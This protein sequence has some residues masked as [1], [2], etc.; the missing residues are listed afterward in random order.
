MP[1]K[2]TVER[3]DSF[4]NPTIEDILAFVNGGKYGKFFRSR[5]YV[6]KDGSKEYLTVKGS[7][8]YRRLISTIYACVRAVGNEKI[9]NS[10]EGLVEELDRIAEG[11][12]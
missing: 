3:L 8:L 6:F 10:V 7:K 1:R 11:E 4:G 2:V 5:P 12:P 9:A